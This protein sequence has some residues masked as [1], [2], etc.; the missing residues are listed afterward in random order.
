M[1]FL[2]KY[3]KFLL[4]I[5]LI[6]LTS[7]DAGNGKEIFI[8]I[9]QLG[10]LPRDIKTGIVFADHNLTGQSFKVINQENNRPALKGFIKNEMGR[11]GNYKYHY[12]IDFTTITEP[13]NYFVEIGKVKSYRFQIGNT[14]Y[15]SITDS[16]L[17]FF[18]AQ[19]CGPT[20]PFLHDVCHLYD[21]PVL[22]GDTNF[23]SVDVT[24]GWHDAGD[25][26][27]FLNTTALT[28]YLLLFSYE[29]DKEKFAFDSDADG[30][31]DILVEARV[32]IDW[33][34]RCNYSKYSLI[35]Q[36]GDMR[37]HEV[38]W[39][40][41][42]N[43]PLK[44]ERPAYAGLGKNQVGLFTAVMALASKIWKER[45]YDEDYS[46]RCF[47]AA[48]NIYSIRNS[49]PNLDSSP[50]KMY[51]DKNFWGKLALGA[52]EMHNI[53]GKQEYLR[54]AQI[55]GDSARS[56]FWWSW[57]DINGLVH[58]RIA[59]KIPRFKEYLKRNLLLFNENKNK[60]IFGEATITSW[61]SSTTF[62]GVA[63]KSILWKKLTGSNEFDSLLIFQRDYILGKNPW[64]L[65][66]IHGIG[67]VFPKNLHSQIAYFNNG[68][69]PGAVTA[70][71]APK[72]VL[73]NY[74]IPRTNFSFNK[75]NSDSILYYDDRA[76][77]V[78]NEPTIVT[79]ATALF[80]FGHFRS[81]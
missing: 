48:Q 76:D 61:G 60:N 73:D 6:V 23:K 16:L 22:I 24:G 57:D 4:L 36:V 28:T 31:P 29:F 26:I 1:F 58:Y 67:T 69:L 49:V 21:S 80:V 45:F 62:L 75:F 25:Y 39:R 12:N 37:D 38:G 41:P 5:L 19:R 65:S 9:N 35:N 14:A 43:D 11:W 70:G 55:Y 27:K 68:Y 7:C 34:L 8:R 81:K 64:G 30:V 53:T 59:Q 32:G 77:Y 63:L 10:F 2:R 71:P 18:R 15:N 3:K 54:D 50:S 72:A 51:Q 46:R 52:I 40:L 79:N 13:G 78:T 42:E 33:L 56:D 47:E 17:K 66:F 44:F 74:Q 20:N